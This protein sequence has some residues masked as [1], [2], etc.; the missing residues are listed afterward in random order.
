M[1]ISHW[2][3]STEW[4]E[5]KKQW[6]RF[7]VIFPPRNVGHDDSRIFEW[8]ERKG[9]FNHTPPCSWSFEYRLIKGKK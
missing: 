8:I 5:K 7:F 3:S 6:H 2:K 4:F 1:K 9:T